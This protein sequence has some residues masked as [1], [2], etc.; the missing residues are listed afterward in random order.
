MTT[1]QSSFAEIVAMSQHFTVPTFAVPQSQRHLSDN[2]LRS[3]FTAVEQALQHKLQQQLMKQADVAQPRSPIQQ[4]IVMP[5]LTFN[6]NPKLPSLV[7]LLKKMQTISS[8]APVE[9]SP[10]QSQ[11][12]PVLRSLSSTPFQQN[13]ISPSMRKHAEYATSRH[14]ATLP[15]W[16]PISLQ[17]ENLSMSRSFPVKKLSWSNAS[18]AQIVS[19]L[20]PYD[21]HATL[22]SR[23][24][25]Y[26]K[27][28]GCER[29]SQRNN[30]C[31]SH[32]GKRLCKENS[33]SSKDRGNGFCIKHGG[34][35]MCSMSCCEKKAR[36]KGLCTQHYR[37]FNEHH[38]QGFVSTPYTSIVQSV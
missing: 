24:S 30:L 10:R 2:P 13:M 28:E 6:N 27:I 37:M 31:H 36:R 25:K 19:S 8:F 26:C 18:S 35:K 7:G 9:S 16:E 22:R 12:S 29:V 1:S 23:A 3:Q 33:C 38:F 4:D 32:G 14:Q 17:R 20:R 15:G 21:G 34:G 11:L 5:S